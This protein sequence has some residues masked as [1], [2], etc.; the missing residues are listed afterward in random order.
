VGRQEAIAAQS[1]RPLIYAHLLFSGDTGNPRHGALVAAAQ[2]GE[3]EVRRAVLFFDLEWIALPEPRAQALLADPALGRY[4]HY[5]E[6]ARRERPYILSEPEEKVLAVT[7]NTGRLA[8]QRLFDSVVGGIRCQVEGREATLEEALSGLYR[9]ERPA[10]QA[11]AEAITDALLG[12]QRVLTF[13]LNTLVQEH[14]D[15]DRLRSRPHAM[16]ARNLANEIEQE[17]VDALLDACDRSM[18]LVR[19]Y[20]ALKRR[21][22]GVDTLYDHDRYAPIG[23]ELP[24]WSWPEARRLVLQAYGEFSPRMAE[25]VRQF[26]ERGWIDAEVRP[27]KT[28]GAFSAS[29]LPDVHPY[30][31]LNYT[32][33]PRDV[34]TLAHELGHGVHQYLARGRGYFQ[35]STPLTTAETASVFG[36]MLAF[37]RLLAGQPAPRQQLALLCGKLEDM[38]MTVHRQAALTRFEQALHRTRREQGELDAAAI[39]EIWLTANRAMYG[40]SVVLTGRYTHWWGYISHFVHSPF[41]CYAYCFGE[42]LVLAL[43]RRYEQEGSPFVPRYLALLEAGGSGAPRDLLRP[44]GVD[45]DDPAF[46]DQ[47][48]ALL[49]GWLRKA[50]ALAAS[51]GA[52]GSAGSAFLNRRSDGAARP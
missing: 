34:M 43:Y 39:G 15:Q 17:T 23:A 2:E 50:E 28:G 31:L 36:E 33:T 38:F 45:I 44:L 14:A 47:G 6:V 48:M 21:L 10:R 30:I 7:G 26:L 19:R 18:P 12:Q 37:Q 8:F 11:A 49:E 32:D 13:A 40:D 22:L 42:L 1:A 25:I 46:W 41:Y 20:Y 3:S 24:R 4:R 35:Q 5:L 16:R 9:P 29:T 52:P 51:L 27:G